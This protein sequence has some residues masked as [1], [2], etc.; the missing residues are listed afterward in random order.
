MKKTVLLALLVV[1]AAFSLAVSFIGAGASYAQSPAVEAPSLES[2]TKLGDSALEQE[3]WGQA[4][5]FF[6][7]IL[8]IK[9]EHAPAYLG[10]LLA[11]L[12]IKSEAY[13][14]NYEKPL[15][16][17]LNYQKTLQFADESFRAKVAG[18]NQAIR[19]RIQEQERQLIAERELQFAEGLRQF[20][21]GGRQIGAVISFGGLD[22]R[23]LDVK[24]N[25]ALIITKDLI[26]Q[27]QYNDAGEEEGAGAGDNVTWETCTLRKYLNG[28]F[29]EKFTKEE[30]KHIAETEIQNPNNM[31]YDTNGGNDTTDKIFL[32]SL[33]E[34]DKYFGDS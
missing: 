16:D 10:K 17:M 15:D 9:P 14:E 4:N 6:D 11:E 26:E 23:V 2:L 22:W 7:K 27:R 29:Y 32:L 18:Y 13:L 25:R 5:D 21:E 28:E 19:T 8:E 12:K 3:N 20:N 1:I 30:Q 34:V 24:D 31:W 33:Q